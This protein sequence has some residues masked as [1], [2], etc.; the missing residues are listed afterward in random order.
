MDHQCVNTSLAST[1]AD[2]SI[3]KPDMRLKEPK[4]RQH[5]G[6]HE[7]QDVSETHFDIGVLQ[8]NLEFQE[9]AKFWG[10]IDLIDWDGLK[11]SQDDPEYCPG[12]Q[13]GYNLVH[14]T[15][16][17]YFNAPISMEDIF[18]IVTS[19]ILDV[20][21]DKRVAAD[22]TVGTVSKRRWR[23][24]SRMS[25]RD[26]IG[27]FNKGINV[28]EDMGKKERDPSRLCV[29]KLL[30]PVIRS[31]ESKC[32]IEIVRRLKHPNITGYRD[33]YLPTRADHI[34]WL[35]MEYVELLFHSNSI[36]EV[37]SLY[38]PDSLLHFIVY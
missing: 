23:I 20:Q 5:E 3:Q 37:S 36:Y 2:L 22:F 16:N 26:A 6:C 21:I 13:W 38:R 7:G 25:K 31:Q 18:G 10:H 4:K 30:D 8:S 24:I 1:L 15:M 27:S 9:L 33:S 19:R 34:P 35:C 14:V 17:A 32:E 12:F 28:V 29:Q 11:V